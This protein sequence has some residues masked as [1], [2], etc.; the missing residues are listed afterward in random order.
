MER[1]FKPQNFE[2]TAALRIVA[3]AATAQQDRSKSV[4]E[5]A[6][7]PS[8]STGSDFAQIKIHSFCFC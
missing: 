1:G 3:E 5:A 7:S 8:H 6:W 2:Q 4:P